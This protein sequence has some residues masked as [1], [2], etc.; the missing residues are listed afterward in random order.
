M[1][2]IHMTVRSNNIDQF[3]KDCIG[4]GC[5]PLLIELQNDKTTYQQV[6]TS[7]KFKHDD[8]DIEINKTK[9]YFSEKYPIERIKVE[10]NPYSS[11][12]VQVKYLET[13][14]RIIANDNTA[15]VLKTIIENNS[16]HQSKNIFKKLNE[17]EFYQMATYRTYDLDITRFEC[18]VESF[19]EVLRE[20]NFEYDRVEV[21]ACIIDTND[22]LDDKWLK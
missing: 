7:Q 13:H 20:N 4:F 21:E 5:K 1:F 8:W 3:K 18:V 2:E 12:E 15:L 22:A 6:M 17:T 9:E 14:F 10:I 16:F 19:K 11:K